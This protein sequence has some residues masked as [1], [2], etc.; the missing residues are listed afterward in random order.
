M[1]EK[2]EPCAPL[3]CMNQ[4][5]GKIRLFIF[6]LLCYNTRNKGVVSTLCDDVNILESFLASSEMTRLICLQRVRLVFFYILLQRSFDRFVSRRQKPKKRTKHSPCGIC[7]DRRRHDGRFHRYQTSIR[8]GN[9]IA[10]AAKTVSKDQHRRHL[11]G[12]SEES[13]KLLLSFSGQIRS[14]ALDFWKRIF[15]EHSKR[16]RSDTRS[17]FAKLV[18]VFGR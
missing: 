1:R 12:M 15:V 2:E 9:E 11:C 3:F 17:F 18:L 7:A 14:S 10:D 4:K 16:P 6:H 8:T 13:K 5:I